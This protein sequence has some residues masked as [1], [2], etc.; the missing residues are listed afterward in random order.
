ML[1]PRLLN[2]KNAI[3][4]ASGHAF[5]GGFGGAVPIGGNGRRGTGTGPVVIQRKFSHA[6]V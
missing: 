4:R 5:G 3:P 6:E 2:G 1:E